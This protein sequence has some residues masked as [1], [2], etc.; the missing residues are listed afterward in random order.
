[1]LSIKNKKSFTAGSVT[2]MK[3]RPKVLI[4]TIAIDP[5]LNR[6]LCPDIKICT[7]CRGDN[8]LTMGSTFWKSRDFAKNRFDI[9]GVGPGH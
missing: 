7:D 2:L 6:R 8:P 1:M 4:N 5:S 3:M 9:T